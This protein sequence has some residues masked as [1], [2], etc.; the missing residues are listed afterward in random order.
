[1]GKHDL[2]HFTTLVSTMPEG[3]VSNDFI[4][5]SLF[6][7]QAGKMKVLGDI[8]K[9]NTPKMKYLH[10]KINQIIDRSDEFL[11]ERDFILSN[12][13]I[14]RAENKPKQEEMKV[15]VDEI[16]NLLNILKIFTTKVKL[17]DN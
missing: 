7:Y 1:M 2:I 11:A 16:L 17:Y 3:I 13:P 9:G 4:R 8:T 15:K 5:Y 10:E 14:I 12:L 6:F